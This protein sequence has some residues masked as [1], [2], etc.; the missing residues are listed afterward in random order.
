MACTENCDRIEWTME[1][2]RFTFAHSVCYTLV[3]AG[4]AWARQ[5]R[6]NAT[7]LSAPTPN[8][9]FNAIRQNLERQHGWMWSAGGQCANPACRCVQVGSREKVASFEW[10]HELRYEGPS[11]DTPD[12]TIICEATLH[13]VVRLTMFR[14]PQQC[15]VS[16]PGRFEIESRRLADRD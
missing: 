4:G 16:L 6:P 9:A 14:T 3:P 10:E 2:E 8:A 13:F 1:L 7:P 5:E 15:V 12:A 11:P